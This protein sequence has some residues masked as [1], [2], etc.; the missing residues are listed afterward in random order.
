M[1]VLYA[2]CVA[3][4]ERERVGERERRKIVRGHVCSCVCVSLCIVDAARVA[5]IPSVATNLRL[6][7]LAQ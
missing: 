6:Y 4:S 1:R 3:Q 2:A 5:I 7:Y